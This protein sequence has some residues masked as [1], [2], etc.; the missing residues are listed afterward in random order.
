MKT[1]IIALFQIKHHIIH[2]ETHMLGRVELDAAIN[3]ETKL[4][5]KNAQQRS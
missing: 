2:Y 5:P 4:D 3:I 1:H